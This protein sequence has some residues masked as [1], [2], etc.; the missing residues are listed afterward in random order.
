MHRRGRA[1]A[2]AV[3]IAL[4]LV[5]CGTREPAAPEVTA[6][7]VTAPE[8][9]SRPVETSSAPPLDPRLTPGA[10]TPV[11][12]LGPGDALPLAPDPSPA[13]P[14]RLAVGGATSALLVD[15]VVLVWGDHP[16]HRPLRVEHAG[17]VRIAGIA[18]AVAAAVVPGGVAILRADGSVHEVVAGE[19]G[20]QRVR[21]AAP[22][23]RAIAS[24]PGGA[25]CVVTRRG[26][27]HCWRGFGGPDDGAPRARR[28]ASVTGARRIA[29][30]AGV[31]A[32]VL[33]DGTVR[34]FGAGGN[35]EMGTGPDDDVWE[36]GRVAHP[37]GLAGVVDVAAIDGT[38]CAL[39]GD[40]TVRCWGER[41]G[42]PSQTDVTPTAVEGLDGVVSLHGGGRLFCARRRDGSVACFG[43]GVIGLPRAGAPSRHAAP[44]EAPMARDALELAIGGA[45]AC[46][47][48]ADGSPRC[49]G[50][51]EVGQLGAL[52][53]RTVVARVPA[54]SGARWVSAWGGYSC[55][56]GDAGAACW[57][58]PSLDLA[59]ERPRPLTLPSIERAA[60]VW[61]DG[62]RACVLGR[63]GTR[64][65]FEELGA[66]RSRGRSEGVRAI[67]GP[68]ALF[69][70]GNVRCG[71]DAGALVPLEGGPFSTVAARAEWSGAEVCAARASGEGVTCGRFELD[72][73]TRAPR[74]R[75]TRALPAS[76]PSEL[77]LGATPCAR[78]ERAVTC[79]GAR[80]PFSVPGEWD[81]LA[82]GGLACARRGGEVACWGYLDIA[83]LMHLAGDPHPDA[84][85][86]PT[87]IPELR[88]AIALAVG[89]GHGCALRASGEVACFGD[90]RSGGVGGVPGGVSVEPVTPRLDPR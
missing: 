32:A 80:G 81:E 31:G 88:D 66:P 52:P 19:D 2:G 27:V 39:V 60:A 21:V 64:E 43:E 53:R 68:C 9:P 55:A 5:A 73:E 20:E 49:V 1:R 54:I 82:G 7:E 26:E 29:I 86:R 78:H 45:H 71:I 84:T 24:T 41:P 17:P 18:D 12:A 79:H 63:D 50:A 23:A 67:A 4:A 40:G 47:I 10:G 83:Q 61:M 46:W 13:R 36:E 77:A 3:V 56:G 35:A 25:A 48:A 28:I 72:R 70:D 69:E 33:E 44:V 62:G 14:A 15:G 8:A 22:A 11:A 51:N 74:L 34:T 6:P 38:F 37:V 90:T 65:C 57:G 76:A 16:A 59:S 58:A 75:P 85:D 30:R 89:G 87:P 42:D